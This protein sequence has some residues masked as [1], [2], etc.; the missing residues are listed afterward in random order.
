MNPIISYG[1]KWE[2]RVKESDLRNNRRKTPELLG[3]SEIILKVSTA[4]FT[5]KLILVV[6]GDDGELSR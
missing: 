6:G 1:V 2:A 5:L 4:S 3:F